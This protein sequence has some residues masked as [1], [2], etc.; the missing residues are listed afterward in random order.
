MNVTTSYTDVP[1]TLEQF[2]VILASIG[3]SFVR[4]QG[5]VLIWK[6]ETKPTTLMADNG[7]DDVFVINK[8]YHSTSSSNELVF[9]KNEV[10]GALIRI[11]G[12]GP[13]DVV[14]RITAVLDD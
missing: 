7:W 11:T 10:A 4:E 9:D 5:N 3:Y 13:F 12:E 8:P 2:K 1:V 6:L 14:H